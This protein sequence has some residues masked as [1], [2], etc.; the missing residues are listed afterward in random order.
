MKY[1]YWVTGMGLFT[2]GVFTGCGSDG[3]GGAGGDGGGG[4]GGAAPTLVDPSDC[5]TPQPDYDEPCSEEGKECTY[6]TGA[7]TI[8]IFCRVSAPDPTDPFD[9]SPSGLVWTPPYVNDSCTGCAGGA[10]CVV[11]DEV[12]DSGEPCDVVGASCPAPRGGNC[13][14]EW[15]CTKDHVW[16]EQLEPHC[17]I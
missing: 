6:Q 11:C 3:G 9:C 15:F 7:C 17:C 1:A 10:A 2:L 5:P 8:R 13:G 16:V 4:K 12:G 14:D